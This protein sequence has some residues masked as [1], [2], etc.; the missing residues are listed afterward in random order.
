MT[1]MPARC[2]AVSTSVVAETAGVE[3]HHQFFARR[4]DQDALDAVDRIGVG[5][6]LHQGFVER[7]LQAEVL[8]NFGHVAGKTDY[9]ESCSAPSGSAGPRPGAEAGIGAD[10]FVD[11]ALGAR[12]R[13]EHG[14]PRAR[15][16][17]MAAE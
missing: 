14:K 8:L 1:G 11:E 4:R 3:L 5:D 17:V 16:A 13:F 12:D 6:L 9:S 10:G 15:N 2:S 7:T